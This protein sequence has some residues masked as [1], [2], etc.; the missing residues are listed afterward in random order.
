VQFPWLATQGVL[1]N[2][3]ANTSRSY[4]KERIASGA[5]FN[6]NLFTVSPPMISMEA[7]DDQGKVRDSFSHAVPRRRSTESRVEHT[8]QV[9]QVHEVLDV[10]ELPGYRSARWATGSSAG[11]TAHTDGAAAAGSRRGMARARSPGRAARF[12]SSPWRVGSSG[13]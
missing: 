1:G 2:V 6:G 3:N 12:A 8:H 4:C 9:Q 13:R 5:F 10:V 7:I 11:T